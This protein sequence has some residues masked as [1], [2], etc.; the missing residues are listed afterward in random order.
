MAR[1]GEAVMA[2]RAA[3]VTELAA[4]AAAHVAALTDATET[5]QITHE[6]G[7]PAPVARD[8]P[9]GVG[10]DRLRT[11][12]EETRPA[13]LERGHTRWG[14]HRGDLAL[15]LDGRDCRL[16]ASQ[17]QTRSVALALRLAECSVLESSTGSPPVLLLD[18]V[19]GELDRRRSEHFIRL[20]SRHGVQ[21]ILTATD[22]APLEAELPI[23]ARFSVA[24]G[25]IRR[26]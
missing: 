13:D 24:G 1:W 26:V 16:Y 7:L 17:G 8:H 3:L 23:A 10:A 15:A 25:A 12:W 18:D 4:A 11:L 14:P 22:A 2:R 20:L 19:L 21:S 9:N 5:L 6:A